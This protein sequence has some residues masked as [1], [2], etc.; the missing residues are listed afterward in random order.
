MLSAVCHVWKADGVTANQPHPCAHHHYFLIY[1]SELCFSLSLTH[2]FSWHGLLPLV[3]WLPVFTLTHSAVISVCS[4]AVSQHG[5]LS[6][7]ISVFLAVYCLLL[8]L[9]VCLSVSLL[10]FSLRL[11]ICFCPQVHLSSETMLLSHKQQMNDP[12]V[13]RNCWCS[14]SHSKMQNILVELFIIWLIFIGE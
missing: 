4:S 12:V 11:Y 2:S 1:L 9:C 6:S 14:Y 7:F 3:L 13:M 8:Y 5:G 10:S